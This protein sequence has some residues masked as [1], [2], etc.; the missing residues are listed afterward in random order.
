MNMTPEERTARLRQLMQEHGLKAED[1]GNILGIT[2]QTVRVYR[3]KN[4]QTITEKNLR[5]LE[6]ELK[7]IARN[8]KSTRAKK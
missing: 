2:A 6:L 5:L 4:A 7:R 1:V 8:R 3:S